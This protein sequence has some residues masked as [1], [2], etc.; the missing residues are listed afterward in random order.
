M[1][2]PIPPLVVRRSDDAGAFFCA[3]TLFALHHAPPSS[4]LRRD[5]GE[6][7]AG[8][9][10]VP[11]DPWT[12]SNAPAPKAERFAALGLVASWAMAGLETMARPL[13]GEGE[14][15]RLLLTGFGPFRD[16][17][18]N[19]TGAFIANA[20]ALQRSVA[21]AFGDAEPKENAIVGQKV[22]VLPRELPVDD[23]LLAGDDAA[24]LFAICEEIRPHSILALG[25]SRSTSFDIETQPTDAGLRNVDG[26]WRHEA[27]RPESQRLSSTLVLAEA[28]DRGRLLLEKRARPAQS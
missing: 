21:L 9:L 10:H 20:D 6:P 28:I 8:F 17:T 2:K 26:T 18:N 14:A 1:R 23:R 4:L 3:H 15:W 11:P 27:N 22:V 24:S 12:M 16:V 25:V 5:G 13:L 7:L 19:P